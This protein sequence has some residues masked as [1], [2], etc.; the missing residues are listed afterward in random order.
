MRINGSATLITGASSGIGAATARL[1]ARRG[2]RVLL[3]ARNG[4]AL[5]QVAADIAARGGE[6]LVFPADLADPDAPIRLAQAIAREVGTPDILVNNAGVGRWLTVE[7]TSAAEAA[8]M[9]A[10]PYFA[11]FNLTR[12]L[13]PG[14]LERGSGH[15]V[16]VSS[17]ASR[18]V[19]PGAAAYTA[20]R[21][22]FAGFNAALR[23]ELRGS[24]IRVTLGIFG[25]VSSDYWTHNPGS[26]D[27]LPRV[28]RL[29]PVLTPEQTA[30]AIVRGIEA[31][32]RQIVRPRIFRFIFLL[33]ALF[34]ENTEWMLR[35]GWR[36]V[37]PTIHPHLVSPEN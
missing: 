5:K 4:A 8:R 29:L 23:T 34:P 13:L 20:A 11:A 37:Q 35:L 36:P 33:N 9:M 31:N 16:N 12:E 6:A 30:Q 22:A 7:E 15:I 18:I 1:I 26:A 17:V 25:T 14:M 3:V 27:R 32:A 21:W 10:V 24:G 28:N 2:G 19:W